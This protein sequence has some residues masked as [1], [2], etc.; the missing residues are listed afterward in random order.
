MPTDAEF[1]MNVCDDESVEKIKKLFEEFDRSMVDIFLGSLKDFVLEESK[2]E[3]KAQV[4]SSSKRFLTNSEKREWVTIES[5]F[6]FYDECYRLVLEETKR[7]DALP[8]KGAGLHVAGKEYGNDFIGRLK[9][10]SKT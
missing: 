4:F 10:L 8:G 6:C 5:E 1:V 7:E 2:I 3:N 9:F